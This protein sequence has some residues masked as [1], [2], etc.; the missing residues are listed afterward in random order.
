MTLGFGAIVAGTLYLIDITSRL[1]VLEPRNALL[2]G[3][4]LGLE[5]SVGNG[6]ATP[7]VADDVA[8]TP[9]TAD[10]IQKALAEGCSRLFVTFD[11]IIAK[12]EN[13]GFT[14]KSG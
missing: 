3:V 2:T 5:A 10:N 12:A 1:A 11:T 7:D 9:N 13:I 14:N 6:T 4:Q 8:L